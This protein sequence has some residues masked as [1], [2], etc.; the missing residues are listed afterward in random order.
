LGDLI[1][2]LPETG[3]DEAFK[4]AVI[5]HLPIWELCDRLKHDGVIVHH[6]NYRPGWI[7]LEVSW[8][9]AHETWGHEMRMS[10]VKTLIVALVHDQGFTFNHW[11][12]QQPKKVLWLENGAEM[13]REA[14]VYIRTVASPS[15]GQVL[16][17]GIIDVARS[18]ARGEVN[19]NILASSFKMRE[20]SGGHDED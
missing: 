18:R 10:A 3:S 12:A 16:E 5:N 15:V 11:V 9:L 2:M 1:L 7:T 17:D 20:E 4:D 13:S 6:F 8:H 14:K 19:A